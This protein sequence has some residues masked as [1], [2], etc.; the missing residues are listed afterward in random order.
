M[1]E[2]RLH[3]RIPTTL[4]AEVTNSSGE[5]L[6]T[7]I[8]D[9][10]PGGLMLDGDLP[11]KELVFKGYDPDKDPLFHPVELEIRIHLSGQQQCFF[12]RVRLLYIRRLSQDQFNLGFR[13]VAISS[14]HAQMMEQHIFGGEST[15]NALNRAFKSL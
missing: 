1:K 10:S 14:I 8:H 5:T 13:Y 15:Q 12:S 2:L 6:T 7:Q 11:L 4:M 9:L 3:P